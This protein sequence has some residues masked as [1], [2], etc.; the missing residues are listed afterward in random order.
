MNFKNLSSRELTTIIVGGIIVVG[1]LLWFFVI[2][3]GQK[4]LDLDRRYVVKYKKGLR[5][6]K[7]KLRRKKILEVEY[8]SLISNFS[9]QLYKIGDMKIPDDIDDQLRIEFSKVDSIYG[10][11]IGRAR[12]KKIETNGVYN[13]FKYGLS[14]VQCDWK[15]LNAALYLI[16]NSGQLVGFDN[17]SI[18]ADTRDRKNVKTK[19][20][21]NIESF[22][23]PDR[24][25]KPWKMPDY[26]SVDNNLGKNIFQIPESMIPPAKGQHGIKPGQLPLFTRNITLTGIVKFGG[27]LYA[28]FKDKAKKKECRI[29]INGVISNTVP[30]A[31]VTEI[32]QKDEYVNI[33]YNGETFKLPLRKYRE[34]MFTT[35]KPLTLLTGLRRSKPED[36]QPSY[37]QEENI[38]EAHDTNSLTLITEKTEVP[39]DYKKTIGSYSEC[40]SKI[41]TWIEKVNKYNKRR[42]RLNVDHGMIITRLNRVSPLLKVGLQKRDVIVSIG[43]T[44]VDSN[45]TFTY[46]MN[47]ACENGKTFSMTV[48]RGKKLKKVT[49]NL[50]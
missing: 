31:I 7:V 38:D 34:Q 48:M 42:F 39:E 20:R 14:D 30:S 5:E 22:I 3:T 28:I 19:V 50:E 13:L 43:G 24:G 18:I 11:S 10:S 47:K 8:N 23:F 33:L 1:F 9:N 29:G 21:M 2:D 37:N 41:K 36:V 12:F 46:A 32:N 17:L 44:R 26:S 16:E 45:S 35:R 40:I 4:K 49:V 27:K 25:T 6:A 15:S